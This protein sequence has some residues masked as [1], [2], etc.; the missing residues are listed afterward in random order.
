MLGGWLFQIRI[1]NEATQHNDR[2]G[3]SQNLQRPALLTR[4]QNL[5]VIVVQ[6]ALEENFCTVTIT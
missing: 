5:F 1:A 2:G 6:T 4:Q 3:Y